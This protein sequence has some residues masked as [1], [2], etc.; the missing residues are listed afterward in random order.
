[1]HPSSWWLHMTWLR[2]GARSS[3]TTMMTCRDYIIIWSNDPI[4]ILHYNLKQTMLETGGEVGNIPVS[5]LLGV[6]LTTEITLYAR[7]FN[8]RNTKGGRAQTLD[9]FL[10]LRIFIYREACETKIF[11]L[12]PTIISLIM[13]FVKT[14]P[15]HRTPMATLMFT[16]DW[17][18]LT[19][20]LLDPW[21]IF[22]YTFDDSKV[23]CQL[24][25]FSNFQ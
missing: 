7:H 11:Y 8:I 2:M 1:M 22:M 14:R 17:L 13:N 23:S 20:A 16:I 18:S 4:S 9:A 3:V 24:H 19:H 15:F 5:L 12:P 10:G 25:L 6:H 21:I